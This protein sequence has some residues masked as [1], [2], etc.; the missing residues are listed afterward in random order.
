MFFLLFS[1]FLFLGF[2]GCIRD[3]VINHKKLDPRVLLLTAEVRE[4]SLDNCQLVDPCL[5]PNAC[6]HGGLCNSQ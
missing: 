2:V 6:E 5:R 1:F 3:L 4:I